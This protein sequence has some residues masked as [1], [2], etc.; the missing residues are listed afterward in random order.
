MN[1][2]CTLIRSR[3]K[4]VCLDNSM[5]IYKSK[6][7]SE[8]DIDTL[9]PYSENHENIKTLLTCKKYVVFVTMVSVGYV[10]SRNIFLLFFHFVILTF[11]P[12]ALVNRVKN[13]LSPEEQE[14]LLR[15]SKTQNYSTTLLPIKSVGVQVCIFCVRS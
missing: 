11:Q 13:G 4:Q 15:I 5:Q 2:I 8:N 10:L 3:I 9:Y 1:N 7:L 12:H 6:V 14:N